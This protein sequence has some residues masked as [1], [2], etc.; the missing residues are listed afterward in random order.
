MGY[1]CE[2]REVK[3]EIFTESGLVLRSEVRSTAHLGQPG[4]QRS[5]GSRNLVSPNTR[6]VP[7]DKGGGT[8]NRAQNPGVAE[9]WEGQRKKANPQETAPQPLTPSLCPL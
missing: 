6:P 3:E 2:G 5:G 4:Q 9:D 7:G 1:W 8:P